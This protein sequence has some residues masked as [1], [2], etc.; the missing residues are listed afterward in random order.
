MHRPCDGVPGDEF[1]SV[2]LEAIERGEWS[3]EALIVAVGA[4]RL[5]ELG[6][7]GSGYRTPD[8]CHATLNSRSIARSD[9]GIPATP[10]RGTTRWFAGW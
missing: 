6:N 1:V 9:A 2:G 10:T 8:G 5:R 3:I 4:P 7:W